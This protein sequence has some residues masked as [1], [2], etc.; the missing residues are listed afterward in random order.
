MRDKLLSRRRPGESSVDEGP[1]RDATA[2]DGN[3]FEDST[4]VITAVVPTTRRPGRFEVD[5]NG[6]SFGSL[7]AEGL[8]RLRIAIG[9]DITDRVDAVLAEA[10][11]LAVYDRA[12]NMLAFRARSRAELS[13]ALVRKGADREHVRQAIDRLV[14]QGLID[15]TAFARAFARAKVVG[16]SHSR[17]RVQQELQRKGV[18]PD[19]A[20]EAI[21]EVLVE[22][23]IDQLAL[24][25]AAARRKLRTLASLEPAVRRRRLYGFLL[26]RGFDSGDIQRVM[27]ALGDPVEP[28]DG[29]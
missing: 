9:S 17:R 3:N 21:G 7:S 2:S 11:Q 13:R 15:D 8:G 25:E 28:T 26:R 19:V 4:F 10:A 6:R 18:A 20:A 1:E 23:G 14:E 27:N 12:L 22:E 16:A 5:V 24:L 29:Q